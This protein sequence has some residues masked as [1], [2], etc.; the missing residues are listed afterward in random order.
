MYY[1]QPFSNKVSKYKKIII[2]IA[3]EIRIF[4]RHTPKSVPGGLI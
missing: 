3:G 4:L 1:G 2:P